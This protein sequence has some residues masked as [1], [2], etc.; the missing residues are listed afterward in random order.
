MP[1]SRGRR[2]GPRAP[3]LFFFLVWIFGI[4]RT[5]TKDIL[6]IPRKKMFPRVF[7]SMFYYPYDTSGIADWKAG[8]TVFQRL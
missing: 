4:L 7:F 2:R 6:M 5:S 8:E 3:P 1:A